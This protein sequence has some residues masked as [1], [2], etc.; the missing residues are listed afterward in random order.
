MRYL[1]HVLAREQRFDFVHVIN[2]TSFNG[3]W[4]SIV[5]PDGVTNRFDEDTVFHLLDQLADLCAADEKVQG[6]LI[7]DDCL[8][9]G[10][11]FGSDLWTRIATAGRHYGL[12]VWIS[13]QH[14]YKLP[15]VVRNNSDYMFLL[16]VQSEKVSKELHESFGGVGFNKSSELRAWIL[17]AT[18]DYGVALIDNTA[19]G[20]AGAPAKRMR[21]PKMLRPFKLSQ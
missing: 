5:G 18:K 19:D 1:L 10:C 4:S 15:P 16:G 20:Q 13:A 3:E 11:N 21:A 12:T 9:A 17:G 6:L 2:P 8:G 14:L 7:L